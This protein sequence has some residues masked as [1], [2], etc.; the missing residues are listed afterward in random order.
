M[1]QKKRSHQIIWIG[2]ILIILIV[3][4]SLIFFMVNYMEETREGTSKAVS[5]EMIDL[6][7]YQTK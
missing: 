3:G 1:V 6:P 7:Q 4:P 5:S 2:Y